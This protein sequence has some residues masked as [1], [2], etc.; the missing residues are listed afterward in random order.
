M[1]EDLDAKLTAAFPH[2]YRE[3]HLA[4]EETGLCWGYECGD[5]WFELLWRLSA[6]LEARIVQQ[7]EL[8]QC[9]AA[10]VKQKVGELRVYL[11]SST[12]ELERLILAAT[13]E[14]RRICE[15]CGAPGERATMGSYSV[16]M[17]RC[18]VHRGQPVANRSATRRQT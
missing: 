16:V 7:P 4:P 2:L 14:S 12:W 9:C 17:T 10:R 11:R 18:P 15:L 3:R 13:A 8:E 5:G 1:R 6:Q